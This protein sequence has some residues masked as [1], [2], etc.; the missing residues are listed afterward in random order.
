MLDSIVAEGWYKWSAGR[1]RKQNDDEQIEKNDGLFRK[2]DF[3]QTPPSIDKEP[4]KV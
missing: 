4:A 3:A 1:S 2:W